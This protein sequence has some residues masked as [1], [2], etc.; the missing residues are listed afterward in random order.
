MK[1]KVKT[2]SAPARYKVAFISSRDNAEYMNPLVLRV[3]STELH[4]SPSCPND[5]C[6]V[7]PSRPHITT[8]VHHPAT[9]CSTQNSAFPVAFRTHRSP[10]LSCDVH[11]VGVGAFS[12]EYLIPPG[13]AVRRYL[14]PPTRR[15]FG[16]DLRLST[17]RA[18]YVGNLKHPLWPHL[19]PVTLTIPSF[20]C[21]AHSSAFPPALPHDGNLLHRP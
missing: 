1:N 16:T 8:D 18:I 20:A 9:R 3:F 4:L 6:L 14:D 19:F 11:H 5:G 21:S 7:H 15:V 10:P 13:L 17:D 12:T 2:K